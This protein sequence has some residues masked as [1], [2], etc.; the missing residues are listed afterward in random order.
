MIALAAMLLLVGT[1]APALAQGPAQDAG[2]QGFVG[3]QACASCHEEAYEAWRGSHHDWAMDHARPETVLGDFD[4]ATVT[5]HGVTSRFFTRDGKYLV[6]TEGADGELADFEILYTFGVEPLQQYLV[7][8]PDGRLQALSLAWDT[9]PAAEGGQRWFHLYPDE[10][11]AHD[12]EL[13][14]TGLQ[15]NWNYMCADCHSTQLDKGYDVEAARFET[16]WAEIDVGCEACHGPGRDHLRWAELDAG[17]QAQDESMGLKILLDE[18]RGVSWPPDL[19][20]GIAQRSVPRSTDRELQVCATCHSRRGT[21]KPGATADPV[22]LDHHMPAFLTEELYHDD[23]QI[24]DE[25]YVWGSFIQSKMN[26]AGVTCSDCHDPHSQKLYAPGDQVCNQCH[27]PA[28]FAVKE[29]HGHPEDSTGADCLGCHMP[30]QT[31]MVVDPRAD[32]SM[33]S[34]RPDLSLEF[35]TPNACSQC[36]ADQD[37]QWAVDTFREMFPEPAKPYQHWTRAFRQARSGLPQAE[38]SLIRVVND[39]STPDIARATA[40]LELAPYLSPLSGQVLERALKDESPLVRIAALRTLEML[41]PANRF[42]FAGHLL[43]DELLAVRA[44]A[45]RVLAGT[46]MNQLG[47]ADRGALQL[48]LKDWFDT[49][50]FNGDRPESRVN[51]GNLQAQGGNAA[52]AEQFYRQA[53]KLDEEFV[54]AYLNL[55]ELY[56]NQGMEREARGVLE[57]GISKEPEAAALHHSLGLSLVR[58][59]ETEAAV[60]ELRRATELDPETLRYGY[61]LG[62]AQNS[63]GDAAGAVKTLETVQQQHPNNRDVLFALATIERDRGELKSARG[64][65]EKMLELNPAD[66]GAEQLRQ[67][68]DARLAEPR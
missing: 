30:K 67:E 48:A 29:H 49:Q 54:P 6:T 61:V 12:D 19:E 56:R 10:H 2:Q 31:Y 47:V 9:R 13:H 50:Q 39:L 40:V 64:W 33:R 22:F 44:E 41:P 38:V 8:F 25:V 65:T 24:M 55:A 35:G 32:H 45:G 16:T 34:P 5:I 66:P 57:Q 14:W 68:L 59:G 60:A 7:P 42:P 43:R 36:H 37:L 46:P 28:K 23:G 52:A 15:Q 63:T 17:R 11:I 21:I 53:L 1:G 26:A 20:S 62:V 27:L 58:S 4:E 3:S 18:R 51:L